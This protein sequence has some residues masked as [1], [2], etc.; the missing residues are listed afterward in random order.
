LRAKTIEKAAEQFAREREPLVVFELVAVVTTADPGFDKMN[1]RRVPDVT[2]EQYLGAARD[3]HAL[4]LLNIQ[5]GASDF[6]TEAEHFDKWLHEPDVGLALDP[7]WAMHQKQ[8]PGAQFGQVT[9][10]T[11][12]SVGEYLSSIVE[13]GDLPEKVLVF[14]QVNNWVLKGEED[15]VQHP[16]VV[17]IK[18]VDGLGPAGT[19]IK[20][21]N[22]LVKTMT[23]GVHAGIKLFFDE[24]TAGGHKLMTPDQVLGLVPEPEYVMYE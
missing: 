14:H 6:L 15:I 2:V 5:P 22:T 23:E 12:N 10:K 13:D 16:G 3:A 8:V 21:Y 19:K 7:E 1:R 9:G 18:S 4:L 17:M 24:D 11:L 20:T